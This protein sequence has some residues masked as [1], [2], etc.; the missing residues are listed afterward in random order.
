VIPKSEQI[1]AVEAAFLLRRPRCG[2]MRRR[3]AEEAVHAGTA[4]LHY[5]ARDMYT[6]I[7]RQALHRR[8]RRDRVPAA[9]RPISEMRALLAK[10]NEH[11]SMKAN[12]HEDR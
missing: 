1:S 8:D 4:G 5:S 6:E 12:A 11:F 10:L 7:A 3:K 9:F 2:E